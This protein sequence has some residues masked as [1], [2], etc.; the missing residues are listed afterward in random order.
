M[1]TLREHNRI[2]ACIVLLFSAALVLSSCGGDGN[3]N[4][5][6][7]TQLWRLFVDGVESGTMTT[8]HPGDTGGGTAVGEIAAPDGTGTMT[9]TLADG[10]I[11]ATIEMYDGGIIDIVG[12]YTDASM[13]GTYV[14]WDEGV[15]NTGEWSGVATQ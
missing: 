15:G 7:K 12:A 13:S 11:T 14:A 6:V 4:T 3:D 8:Y 9:G 1:S 5:D 10:V 2:P